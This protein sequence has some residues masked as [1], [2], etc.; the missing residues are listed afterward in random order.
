MRKLKIR[1]PLGHH[2]HAIRIAKHEDYQNEDLAIHTE[3]LVLAGIASGRQLPELRGSAAWTVTRGK[4]CN[5]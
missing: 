5:A 3:N 2:R 4:L 1:C